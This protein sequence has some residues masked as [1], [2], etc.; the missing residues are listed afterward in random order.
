MD[1]QT[2]LEFAS[3]LAKQAGNIML[4]EQ[5]SLTL[6]Y[7]ESVE[8]VTQADV[9]VDQF[10]HQHILTAFP[11]HQ[12]IS[13][14]TTPQWQITHNPVWIIDPIDGTVNYAHKHQQS[15]VSIAFYQEAQ[16]LLAIVYNPFN[17]E[18]F[19][20]IKGKGAW[21]NQE[22]IECSTKDELNRAII[23]TGFPYHKSN[24]QELAQRLATV[25]DNCADIR[26]LGSAALDICWVACG[27]LDAYYETV[28]LWD[29][30][31]ARLIAQESGAE[32]GSFD[33]Y[34]T[35]EIDWQTQHLLI[36]NPNLH[37]KLNEL[38]ETTLPKTTTD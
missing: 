35:Q 4:K 12:I 14:E 30:A 5:A 37:Y 7:K 31:A 36:S 21:L 17:N 33:P 15:A 16:A 20:A 34:N 38:L 18:M 25:L 28:S 29:C 2:L 11:E 27:R 23:A 8:L 1:T 32:V 24:T 13:E 22:P 10:L 3:N 9:K 26:R 19:S 6:D